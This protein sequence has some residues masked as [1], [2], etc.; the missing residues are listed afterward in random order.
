MS[1]YSELAESLDRQFE[2]GVIRSIVAHDAAAALR[3]LEA[4]VAELET[5]VENEK[6]FRKRDLRQQGDAWH[7]D[8][9][10]KLARVAELEAEN[11]A[12]HKRH[13]HANVILAKLEAERD[14][15]REDAERYRAIKSM[16]WSDMEQIKHGTGPALRYGGMTLDDAVDK[17]R[18]AM[19]EGK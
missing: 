8:S 18:A 11:E 14:R 19:L 10:R 13:E 12:L 1:K 3:E 4:R 2:S 9:S 16:S 15:L 6:A 5:A 17:H 7:A